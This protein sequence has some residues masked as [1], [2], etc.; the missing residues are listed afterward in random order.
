MILA[1][2]M[3]HQPLGVSSAKS[4][5]PITKLSQSWKQHRYPSTEV[6]IQ[7]IWFVSQW[8]TIQPLKNDDIMNFAGKLVE[9][10]NVILTE[11]TQIPKDMHSMWQLIGR[12]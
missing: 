10:E 9:L 7:K 1:H 6:W 5:N 12:H 2:D 4:I 3:V 8:N 11:V